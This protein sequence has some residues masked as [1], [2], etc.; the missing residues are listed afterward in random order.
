R[1]RG[2]ARGPSLLAPDL[3]FLRARRFDML[4]PALALTT[5]MWLLAAPLL[6]LETGVRADICVA[7]A[8]LALVLA[9]LSL[10]SRK[11]GGGLP[12]LG[13]LLGFGTFG[14][15]ASALALTSFGASAV[16][17]IAG[18]MAPVPVRTTV[19]ADLPIA[20]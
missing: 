11:A 3:L 16:G 6:G 8:A 18:G 2:R 14:L 10:W 4:F 15:D 20:A 5:A 13:G 7:V 19:P 17:L 9:P 12:V 1:R